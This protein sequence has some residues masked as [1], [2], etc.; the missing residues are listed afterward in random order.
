MCGDKTII[1]KRQTCNDIYQKLKEFVME[2][3]KLHMKLSCSIMQQ[4]FPEK[5]FIHFPLVDS[6]YLRS[7]QTKLLDEEFTT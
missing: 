7:E 1:L 2:M 3:L 5:L 4:I 6:I